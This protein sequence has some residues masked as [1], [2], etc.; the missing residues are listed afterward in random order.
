MTYPTL[1]NTAVGDNLGELLVY[2]NTVTNNLFGLFI[3]ISFF[4]TVFIGSL[5]MQM[6]FGSRIRPETSFVAGA[7]ATFGFAI[8]LQQYAGILS[9]LYFFAIFILLII[10]IIW[11]VISSK[12]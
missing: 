6:R 2:A 3:T 12:E 10:G 5:V 9:P 1:N 11:V 4:L 8:I 7:F